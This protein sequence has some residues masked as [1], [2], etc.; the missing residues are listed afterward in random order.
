MAVAA[1]ESGCIPPA[2]KIGLGQ[3]LDGR[4]AVH[5]S[6]VLVVEV[7]GGLFDLRLGLRRSKLS[8]PGQKPCCILQVRRR[9]LR[10]GLSQQVGVIESGTD[11]VW[12][13][14]G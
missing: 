5:A 6:V 1:P 10:I 11:L 2:E 7:L 12:V 4:I 9:L 14:S 13:G 8:R 3:R